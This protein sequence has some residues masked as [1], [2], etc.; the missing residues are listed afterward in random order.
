ML[1]ETR[2]IDWPEYGR[3]CK[4]LAG[5]LKSEFDPEEIIA[6][7]G[8]GTVVGATI[9]SILKIDLFP[10]KI[11]M[12]VSEQVVRKQPK[13]T[14]PP[15]AH[16][17]QKRVLLIDDR[18][19]TGQSMREALKEVEKFHPT[20]VA[21]AVLFRGGEYQPDYYAIFSFG[22]VV[23]PWEENGGSPEKAD[24]EEILKK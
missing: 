5:R 2:K 20:N 6:I 17:E 11:S 10:I 15:T 21:T 14:I 12:K 4:L 7:A 16:I 24:E 19:L 23:F 13:L 22:A 3:L 9:A 18:S 1:V 8:G